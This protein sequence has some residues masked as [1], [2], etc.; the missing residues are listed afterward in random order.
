[1]IFLS[2]DGTWELLLQQAQAAADA[3]D[4]IDWGI[5]VD[6][7]IVRTHLHAA[8][9]RTQTPLGPCAEGNDTHHGNPALT[10]CWNGAQS[11]RS[12]EVTLNQVMGTYISAQQLRVSDGGGR[13]GGR[14]RLG[15]SV[16]LLRWGRRRR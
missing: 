8:G 12:Q 1:M 15:Q 4:E 16:S 10:R 2:A 11:R 7:T 14:D 6:S 3:A 13:V 5:S 9:A